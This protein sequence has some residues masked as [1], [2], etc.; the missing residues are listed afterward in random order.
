MKKLFV[1]LMLT[2]ASLTAFAQNYTNDKAHS[3]YLT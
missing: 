3:M 2:A 1:T